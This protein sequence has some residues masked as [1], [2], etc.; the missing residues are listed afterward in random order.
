MDIE[1]IEDEIYDFCSEYLKKEIELAYECE[2][3][4][5]IHIICHHQKKI[6]QS[7]LNF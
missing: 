3:Y 2:T 4:I 7:W 6:M 1:I 5:Y